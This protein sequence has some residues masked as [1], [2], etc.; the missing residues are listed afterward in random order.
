MQVVVYDVAN[1]ERPVGGRY[2]IDTVL[3]VPMIGDEIFLR[4]REFHD[5]K[6]AY[7]KATVRRRRW[8]FSDQEPS[9]GVLEIWVQRQGV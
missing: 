3:G 6:K 5:L 8:I 4:E 2:T 9:S 1:A 7:L